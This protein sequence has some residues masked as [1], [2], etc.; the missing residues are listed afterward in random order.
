MNI[1]SNKPTITRKEIEG[2]LSCLINGELLRGKSVKDFEN[3]MSAIAGMRY[4]LAVNSSTSAYHLVYKALE[5]G[6]GDEVIIPSFFDPH[7]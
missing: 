6:Q 4:S 2:V 1:V 7:T 3:A 5:I